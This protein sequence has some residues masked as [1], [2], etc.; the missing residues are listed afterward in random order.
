MEGAEGSKYTGELRCAVSDGFQVAEVS[1]VRDRHGR[2]GKFD[3][4]VFAFQGERTGGIDLEVCLAPETMARLESD[5]ELMQYIAGVSSP[6][7]PT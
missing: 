6:P 1:R 3:G 7:T 4:V 2:D 5:E